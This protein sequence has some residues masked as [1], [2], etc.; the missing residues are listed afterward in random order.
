M[1]VTVRRSATHRPARPSAASA[2]DSDV[3]GLL[4]QPVGAL[5]AVPAGLQVA[6]LVLGA[7]PVRERGLELVRGDQFQAPRR[8]RPAGLARHRANVF[9]AARHRR[10]FGGA[11]V[12]AVSV[13]GTRPVAGAGCLGMCRAA[14]GGSSIYCMQ[15]GAASLCNC[16]RFVTTWAVRRW[17]PLLGAVPRAIPHRDDSATTTMTRTS[18]PCGSSPPRRSPGRRDPPRYQ[19]RQGH[20]LPEPRFGPGARP[21]VARCSPRSARRVVL[22]LAQPGLSVDRA[23]AWA[24]G[25]LRAGH[26]ELVSSS[27]GS[28][29]SPGRASPGTRRGPRPPRRSCR[30]AGW[31]RPRTPAGRPG[32]RR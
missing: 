19:V 2:I 5:E 4:G 12:T 16:M 31:P 24:R 8:H 13:R 15:Y 21:G 1:L 23:R 32:R 27:R 26:A 14:P 7:G 11:Q 3:A 9:G 22:Y 25:L 20:Q 6:G 29:P 30:P 28:G 17:P 10:G 18:S